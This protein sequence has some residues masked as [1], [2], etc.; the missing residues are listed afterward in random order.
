MCFGIRKS[1]PFHL[2]SLTLPIENHR[3]LKNAINAYADTQVYSL[4]TSSIQYE[5]P[6]CSYGP[7]SRGAY[8]VF[9][10][11]FLMNSCILFVWIIFNKRWTDSF[12]QVS[13]ISMDYTVRPPK[14]DDEWN[15]TVNH[16]QALFLFWR[17]NYCILCSFSVLERYYCAS[18]HRLALGAGAK[19]LQQRRQCNAMSYVLA[20]LQM[21]VEKFVCSRICACVYG[22][23][24]VLMILNG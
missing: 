15:I 22:V 4:L 10:N 13:P 7:I 20:A 18:K 11:V 23:F 6:L 17:T 21:T 19:S 2:A 3:Y 24:R 14:R 12:L 5:A 8:E 16:R 9:D 1:T